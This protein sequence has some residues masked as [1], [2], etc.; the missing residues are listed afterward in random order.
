GFGASLFSLT[1]GLLAFFVIGVVGTV[2]GSIAVGCGFALDKAVTDATVTRGALAK[3]AGVVDSPALGFKEWLPNT[4]AAA[5]T[6]MA[7]KMPK[8]RA[9]LRSSAAAGSPCGLDGPCVPFSR[10]FAKTAGDMALDRVLSSAPGEYSLACEGE[11]NGE[12]IG[13]FS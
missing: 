4:A 11:C 3:T 8:R 7:E 13:G 9:V 1:A 2:A 10:G 6:I 12:L 5:S